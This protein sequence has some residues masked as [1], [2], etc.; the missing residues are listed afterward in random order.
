MD[1]AAQTPP[2]VS[3]TGNLLSSPF[4][5]PGLDGTASQVRAGHEEEI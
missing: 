2:P 3:A 1:P 5:A 4:V